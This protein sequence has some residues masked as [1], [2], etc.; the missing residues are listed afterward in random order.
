VV[1]RF[2]LLCLLSV[3]LVA[4]GHGALGS[5]EL[6]APGARDAYVEQLVARAHELKLADQ[7]QWRKLL[8]YRLGL[9]GKGF[10]GGGYT[11][12][13]DGR[14]FFL[15]ERGKVDPQGELD[16][17]LRGLFLPLSAA[18]SKRD[19]DEHP[20]C[21]FPARFLFLRGA[22]GIDPRRLPVQRCPKAERFLSELDPGSLT[23]IFSA[24]YLNNPA[25][26]FGHTF[27][28]INKRNNLAVGERRELLDFGIDYSAD[29]DTGNAVIY[30]IKGLTGMFP[31]TFKRIP[32]WYKVRTYND[33][34]SRDLWEYELDLTPAQ[35]TLLSAHLWELGQTYFDYYYLSENCSYHILSLIEVANPEL[36]LLDAVVTPVIPADTVKAL[37]KYPSLV[38]RVGFR[39]SLRR[40]FDARVVALDSEQR[41][42]VEE[43]AA[44]AEHALP[45]SLGNTRAIAVL[46]AA[47]DLVDVL[48]ARDLVHRTDSDAA[49]HKQRLLE[50]R[51]TILEPSRPV[52]IEPP[53]NERPE[54]GHG[55]RRVGLG[56][57]T[58]HERWALS[59]EVRLALHD[60]ADP[61]PGY[62]EYSA[63]EFMR[64]RMQFWAPSRFEL[65][66]ASFIRVTSLSAQTRFD[67][68]ISWEF[69][70]GG[71]TI[72]DAACDHCLMAHVSGGAGL[73]F[74]LFD[75]GLS[76]YAMGYGTFGWAPDIAG[77]YDSELRMGI[78]PGG[79][80]RIRLS[81][82]L[83]LLGTG[84]WL[85]LPKQE[86]NQTYRIDAQLRLRV[87]RELTL[88]VEGRYTPNGLEGQALAYTYF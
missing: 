65:E 26:A 66:D 31:G 17:T 37:Y 46:D 63:I 72:D 87:L 22:L 86:P 42:L 23:L 36:Q 30:A 64:A 35:L 62:P 40:Q 68:K 85:W 7:P 54:L 50:R 60:L 14:R 45:S 9:F 3:P 83:I 81:E 15:S 5:V 52:S 57:A 12:E 70:V 43:L 34:E 76:V 51:A 61:T 19:P 59:L 10:L 69:D 44:D 4:C 13:A 29:V 55:S 1:L 75:R 27:L 39:P 41:D 78:G 74:E 28:R 73:G 20:L 49:R 11:S 38:R 56:T 21:R 53:V 48:Y 79:G 24:Y 2:S 80:M 8:H 88:G 77:F 47:A 67:R 82:G 33:Y 84:R 58:S 25:S 71:T 16:A 18:S 32:Y 6:K